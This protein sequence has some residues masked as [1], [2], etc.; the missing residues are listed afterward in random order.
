MAVADDE[1]E[2]PTGIRDALRHD[3]D[4]LDM[5]YVIDPS[6]GDVG[7][8]PFELVLKVCS[9]R[10]MYGYAEAHLSKAGKL[11]WAVA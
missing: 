5:G 3:P 9:K 7:G 8:A 2:D 6:T 1:F 10:C 11:G 4:A